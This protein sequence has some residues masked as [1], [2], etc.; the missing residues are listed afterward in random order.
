M[1]GRINM[2][3]VKV[4]DRELRRAISRIM[5]R[6]SNPQRA[7][8]AIGLIVRNS[9]LKN[10]EAQGR[11]QRWKELKESTIRKK[12]SSRILEDTGRL[13]NS[14]TYRAH[15][16]MVEIGTNVVYAGI[17]QFGGRAGR[18]HSAEI[19]SRPFLMLQE[20]DYNVI[21]TTML[22]FLRRAI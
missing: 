13:R 15:R 6:L 21:K 14:I 22:D 2:V 16:D 17:H 20:E 1:T 18:G 12:G 5:E 11:P 10:F 7:F 3:K 9:V 4:D 19:P 8:K